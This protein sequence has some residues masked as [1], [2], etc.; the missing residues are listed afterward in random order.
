MLFAETMGWPEA[1]VAIASILG[2]VAFFWVIS[3][4]DS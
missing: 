1:A 2:L 3:R 4:S